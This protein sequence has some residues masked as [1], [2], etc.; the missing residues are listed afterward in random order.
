[1]SDLNSI[2]LGREVTSVDATPAIEGTVAYLYVFRGEIHVG[3]EDADGK[4]YD[5]ARWQVKLKK[6]LTMADLVWRQ[7]KAPKKKSTES[8]LES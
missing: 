3:V 6:E 7:R 1:M 2:L 4:L 5:L 8:P